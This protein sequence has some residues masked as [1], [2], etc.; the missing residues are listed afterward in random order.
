MNDTQFIENRK[1]MALVATVV[2]DGVPLLYQWLPVDEA[3]SKLRQ[4]MHKE[5]SIIGEE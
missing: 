3:E 2:Y 5:E 1:D 4:I